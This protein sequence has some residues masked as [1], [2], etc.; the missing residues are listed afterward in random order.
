ME[1]FPLVVAESYKLEYWATKSNR[2]WKLRA[3]RTQKQRTQMDISTINKIPTTK[4]FSL[5]T[6]INEEKPLVLMKFEFEFREKL[7]LNFFNCSF[8][9]LTILIEEK[10]L[11]SLFLDILL[12]EVCFWLTISWQ[13]MFDWE[14][15]VWLTIELKIIGTF[16][17]KW[18][19]TNQLHGSN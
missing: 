10:K 4:I 17:K 6:L 19:E 3:V 8:R 15:K 18:N 5:P 14:L 16:W 7:K 1:E 13:K 9:T 11:L 2:F 12:Q